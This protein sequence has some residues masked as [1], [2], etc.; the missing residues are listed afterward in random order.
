MAE[1][2]TSRFGKWDSNPEDNVVAYGFLEF[3]EEDS[4]GFLY[5][6]VDIKTAIRDEILGFGVGT[7]AAY[8]VT[9]R[10]QVIIR[11]MDKGTERQ[12]LPPK[13]VV[14][15]VKVYVDIYG[16]HCIMLVE[17]DI[18]YTGYEMD[19]VL[20]IKNMSGGEILSMA[21]PSDTTP[22]STNTM[23]IGTT[24]GGIWTYKLDVIDNNRIA[25]EAMNKVFQ[26]T[27]ELAP[28]GIIFETY[29]CQEEDEVVEKTL[30]FVAASNGYYQFTG[31]LPFDDLFLEYITI[32]DVKNKNLIPNDKLKEVELKAFYLFDKNSKDENPKLILHS[33]IMKTGVGA[34]FGVFRDKSNTQ[35]D[36]IVT[37]ST[38]FPYK[39]EGVED[40]EEAPIPQEVYLNGEYLFM[41]YLDSVT[42]VSKATKIIEYSE[43]FKIADRVMGMIYE[44]AGNSLWM[45]SKRFISKLTIASSEKNKWKKL[46][47][48]NKFSKALDACKE[49]NNG[50][51]GYV[52]GLYAD[53]KFAKGSFLD[54]AV[55]YLSSN[56][57]FEEITIKLLSAKSTTALQYYLEEKM[58]LVMEDGTLMQ[59]IILSAWILELKLDKLNKLSSKA[60]ELLS[61]GKLKKQI[62]Q[63]IQEKYIE[64]LQSVLKF[65]KDYKGIIRE[66]ASIIL[67]L[68]QDYGRF[69]DCL[70]FAKDTENY[71][72]LVVYHINNNNV[73]ESIRIIGDL[74]DLAKKSAIMTRYAAI[75]LAKESKE[76]AECL[77]TEFRKFNPEAIIPALMSSKEIFLNA[78]LKQAIEGSTSK[79]LNN[80]YLYFLARNDDNLSA[81]E[82]INFLKEQEELRKQ[83]QPLN[84]DK[85][86]GLNVFK[87][88]NRPEALIRAYGMLELYDDAVRM[89]L[90][91]NFIDIAKE[92]AKLAPDPW[93]CKK[94]WVDIAKHVL[95]SKDASMEASFE[96]VKES[97]KKLVLNDILLYVS[98]KIKLKSFK[99]D[100]TDQV[101]AYDKKIDEFKT[102]I[103]EFNEISQHIY[104]QTRETLHKPTFIP[105][106]KNCDRCDK[107]LNKENDFYVFPCMHTFHWNCLIDWY[108]EYTINANKEES[109]ELR[110]RHTAKPNEMENWRTRIIDFLRSKN[111]NVLGED[112]D[113]VMKSVQMALEYKKG[114]VR[115]L[116]SRDLIRLRL[117]EKQYKELFVNECVLCGDIGINKLEMPFDIEVENDWNVK[118][119]D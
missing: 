86:F 7:E 63:N 1:D 107:L 27:E 115:K 38:L 44:A 61:K 8:I 64:T 15:D 70:S 95:K 50:Y 42:V 6:P 5:T 29:K 18:Y 66:G 90:D 21:F 112:P 39:K 12:V 45:Y 118:P 9:N 83:N 79:P 31:S 52:S 25:E 76:T 88:F 46:V 34:C 119:P 111:Q 57:T 60:G 37:T 49:S 101:T 48:E 102:E 69:K 103:K 80:L 78:Y 28:Y 109:D 77:M 67:Q 17:K 104:K 81:H 19:A 13:G 35:E 100:I 74:D 96:L 33:F 47:E 11:K 85:D 20:R 62:K 30:V 98:S 116:N 82:L 3:N 89:A 113:N 55:H 91:N 94:L 56:R 87:F 75:F 16:Y 24:D 22:T 36:I 71:E 43:E 14:Y 110:A 84:F 92:Y 32:D 99:G 68:F 97:D 73:K 41:L 106:D 40:S 10:R 108:K 2:I 23:L 65:L 93:M 72:S 105:P 54:A 59:G 53:Y 58:K 51:Y 26:F 117:L 114:D 4:A